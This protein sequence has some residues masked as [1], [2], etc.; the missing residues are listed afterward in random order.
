MNQEGQNHD[1]EAT[2]VGLFGSQPVAAARPTLPRGGTPR[3]QHPDRQQVV[4]RCAALDEQLPEDHPVRQVW[5]YATTV[6]CASW[7][8]QIQAVE[9]GAGRP[10]IDPQILLA[11]WLYATL[12]GVGSA[13]ELA[14]LCDLHKVYEWICGGV[15][16]NH[17]TLSAFRTR[18]VE[19]LDQLLTD[20]VAGLLHEGLVTLHRVAQDG[21]RVRASAGAASFRREATLQECQA[22]A[23][24]QVQ[25]LRAELEA[26]PGAASA[27]QR[28]AKERAA[29]ER[30]QRLHQAVAAAQQLAAQRPAPKPA[31]TPAPAPE[32]RDRG[33]GAGGGTQAPKPPP[34]PRVSTTDPEA[35]VMKMPDGGY[36]PAFNV[37]FATAT[38]SRIITGVAVGNCGSDQGQL[39]PMVAQH[40]QR[41]GRR[42]QEMLVDGGYAKKADI[43][44]VSA[45]EVGVTVYAPVQQPKKAGQ[46]R[47]A[48]RAD[49]GDEV[50]D[51]R[52]RMG[53]EPAQRIYKERAATAECTNAQA[54]NRGLRQFLVRGLAKVRAVALWFALAHN[55]MRAV[56]LRAARQAGGARRAAVA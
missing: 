27:R 36:R 55:L 18:N 8:G 32:D 33:P 9:G 16:V 5:A 43:A 10:P 20:S 39:G 1:A 15:G 49:D 3:V 19:F 50:A 42:P 44:Q 51:W 31:S 35:R 13:R 47:Y 22:E 21:V 4:L 34:A 54:R 46:D 12:D 7:Y 48:R 37:Q 2:V 40:Q 17:S 29:R 28:A 53:T 41:Y 11:L 52:A 6:D 45:P 24:A 56:A 26:D 38:G 30:T 25:Q 23:Q 14:R